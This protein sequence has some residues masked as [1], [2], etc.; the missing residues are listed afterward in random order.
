M[1]HR[2]V[3]KEIKKIGVEQVRDKMKRADVAQEFQLPLGTVDYL[4]ATN[5][6]PYSR[7][8]KRIIRF[9]RERLEQ[10]FAEN[11]GR[12]YQRPAKGK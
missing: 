2:P 1:K 4:V 8:S 6:I 7:I 11:E 12:P 3:A 10:W 9:S 5:S